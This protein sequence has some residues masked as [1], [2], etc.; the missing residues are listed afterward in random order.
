[1]T[2]AEMDRFSPLE[3]CRRWS[4]VA[5]V[6]RYTP[7][8]PPSS[9][10]SRIEEIYGIFY[11]A[12]FILLFSK[13]DTD[14]PWAPTQ[15]E[16]LALEM[17]SDQPNA[18]E[19]APSE[20]GTRALNSRR[21]FPCSTCSKSLTT[22]YNLKRHIE[23]A[24]GDSKRHCRNNVPYNRKNKSFTRE[25]PSEILGAVRGGD[26]NGQG[27]IV[28]LL[29]EI[30]RVLKNGSANTHVEDEDEADCADGVEEC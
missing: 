16:N 19:P 18:I 11:K 17:D 8:S 20:S 12:V 13:L 4:L 25:T 22:S 14:Q 23:T 15:L 3:Q 29:E 6:A 9:G 2:T 24:H 28:L 7:S 1:M 21:P 5:Y 30:L 10:Y 26:A 27:M